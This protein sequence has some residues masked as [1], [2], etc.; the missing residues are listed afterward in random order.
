MS[1]VTTMAVNIETDSPMI[2]VVAKPRTGPLPRKKRI[3]AAMRVVTLAS[4]MVQ[5]ARS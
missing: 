3:P 2:S 4:K 1:R 5:K